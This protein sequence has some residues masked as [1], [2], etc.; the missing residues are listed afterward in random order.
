MEGLEAEAFPAD[1]AYDTNEL[2]DMLEE[3]DKSTVITP[4]KS[5]KE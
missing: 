2:F 4:I 5:R 3:A 1:K